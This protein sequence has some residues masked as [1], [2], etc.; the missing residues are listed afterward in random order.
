[1]PT[2]V[3]GSS[4]TSER[5]R[6]PRGV[7][8]LF[9]AMV[10]LGLLYA[11]FMVP[12]LRAG[13]AD[14]PMVGIGDP[15]ALKG[16]F[17]SVAYEIFPPGFEWIGYLLVLTTISLGP[18]IAAAGAIVAAWVALAD[19]RDR[20]ALPAVLSTITWLGFTALLVLALSPWGRTA[21]AWFVD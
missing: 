12:L 17:V 9:V 6:N 19:L 18:P 2:S 4:V 8:A 5:L 20:R 11:S 14:A 1:M 13:L 15:N 10:S 3:A 21:F 16:D 7:A